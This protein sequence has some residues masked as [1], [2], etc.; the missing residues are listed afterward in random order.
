M[1]RDI[2]TPIPT[3]ARPEV[4]ARFEAF[5]LDRD[6]VPDLMARVL[7]RREEMIH[8]FNNPPATFAGRIDQA[9]LDT[10]CAR[11]DGPRSLSKEVG[12]LLAYVKINAA[13]AWSVEKNLQWL[14]SQGGTPVDGIPLFRLLE[15]DYHT[16]ILLSAANVF[17]VRATARYDPSPG[18][19]LLLKAIVNL[20]AGI[21]DPLGLATEFYSVMCF[22]RLLRRTREILG[23][24][25]VLREL[26]EERV[27][28]VLIDEIGHVSFYRMLLGS[29]GLRLASAL[30]PLVAVGLRGAI[31]EAERAGVMPVPWDEL[32][33]FELRDIPDEI[34]ARAFV[35]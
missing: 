20:P 8:R 35:C 3:L 1:A 2:F 27:T 17:G 25:P 34:R 24:E 21:G 4:M 30:L 18:M 7:P 32:F 6:G 12:L 22:N 14:A 26:F 10:Q 16:K 29:S 13:E 19:D 23:D 15:E 9:M 31:P 11:Y 5:L 28:E 33:T